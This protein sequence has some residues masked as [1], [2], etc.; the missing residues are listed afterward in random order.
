[1][2]RIVVALT[3]LL[4]SCMTPPERPRSG[5]TGGTGGD[6]EGTG[7]RGTGGKGT[8]GSDS[9]GTGGR[10]SG[11]TGGGDSGGTGGTTLKPDA[12]VPKDSGSGGSTMPKDGGAK[13]D[14]GK[15]LGP[16]NP[17]ANWDALQLVLANCVYCH[18]DPSKRLNLQYQ[19]LYTRLVNAVAEKSPAGCPNR[20]VVVP[21]DPMSSLLYLKVAGKMPTGCGARMPYN[22]P[23]VTATELKTVFDWISAGA[24][25]Q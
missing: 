19:D 18:N 17:A 4:T 1:V 12:S 2:S 24:P 3:L 13:L 8:G 10:D 7:G 11:G 9:G 6:E 21:G 15:D 22:K 14:A 25:M 20:V 23:P 16:V 5:R